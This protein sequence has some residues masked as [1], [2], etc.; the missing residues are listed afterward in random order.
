MPRLKKVEKNLEQILLLERSAERPKC[1]F[2]M[3]F[4]LSKFLCDI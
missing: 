1:S 4:I 2:K 3:T